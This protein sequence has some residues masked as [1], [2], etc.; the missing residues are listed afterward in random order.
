MKKKLYGKRPANKVK[1]FERTF[2]KQSL[3]KK[4]EHFLENFLEENFLKK[5][6]KLRETFEKE[7]SFIFKETTRIKIHIYINF[8]VVHYM[9]IMKN[10]RQL[11]ATHNLRNHTNF[12]NYFLLPNLANNLDETSN[13]LYL[14]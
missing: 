1:K 2:C 8:S 14:K 6:I 11:S 9:H 10:S 7:F 13:N 4:Y 12:G 3:K 5:K